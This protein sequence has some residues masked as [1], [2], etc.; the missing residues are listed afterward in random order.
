MP[1]PFGLMPIFGVIIFAIVIS[2]FIIF[3]V[4]G[5]REWSSNNRQPVYSDH[6]LVVDK[7]THIWRHHHHNHATV[8]HSTSTSCYITF[9]FEDGERRE[10]MVPAK[11]YG[12]T[13]AGDT[14]TLTW[15]GTRFHGFERLRD[16]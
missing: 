11:L 13:V 3:A 6:V 15:Q 16:I 14:G 1:F 8:H 4:R 9:E 12:L 5:L 7:R 10:F 2:M